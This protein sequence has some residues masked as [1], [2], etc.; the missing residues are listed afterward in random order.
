[1]NILAIDTSGPM[2]SVAV[3]HRGQ[4]FEHALSAGFQHA[5]LLLPCID[6]LFHSI[7]LCPS[8]LDLITCT[9]GP[10][11]FTGLRIGMATARGLSLAQQIPLVLLPSLQVYAL[12]L[13]APRA[14]V[15][16]DARKQRFYVA[17]ANG[18][19]ELMSNEYDADLACI[20][21]LLEKERQQN[22]ILLSGPGAP[23]LYEQL[24]DKKG[25]ILDAYALRPRAR[26]MIDLAEKKWHTEGACA[27]EEGPHY[28]RESD[29]VQG[30]AHSS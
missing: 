17:M 27:D 6:T 3:R 26:M 1:M 2:I 10:G 29:A 21:T 14:L 16:L 15:V 18:Q 4:I 11:S 25:I 23:L 24:S 30:Q 5:Q 20:I 12:G 22:D 8:H 28:L 7:G 19:G 13:H 9:A